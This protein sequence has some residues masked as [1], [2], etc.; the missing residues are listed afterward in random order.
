MASKI[1]M[2]GGYIAMLNIR[3]QRFVPLNII[4]FF[5]SSLICSKL[6]SSELILSILVAFMN[7]RLVFIVFVF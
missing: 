7:K 4:P 1:K 2:D 5:I 6:S 3:I